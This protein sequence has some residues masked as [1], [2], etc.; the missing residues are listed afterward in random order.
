MLLLP[1]WRHRGVGS[2]GKHRANKPDSVGSGGDDDEEVLEEEERQV[3]RGGRL[4][5]VHDQCWDSEAREENDGVA[6]QVARVCCFLRKCCNAGRYRRRLRHAH[7]AQGTPRPG[8]AGSRALTTGRPG[9]E[10]EAGS[11]P[12]GRG[13][14]SRRSRCTARLP[15]ASAEGRHGGSWSIRVSGNRRVVFRFEDNEAVD[16]DLVDY[17]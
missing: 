4:R 16:V 11:D 8:R 10:A 7:Q 9:A 5:G 6:G 3:P 15:P 13:A 12:V 1:G 2:D 17:Q 14:A